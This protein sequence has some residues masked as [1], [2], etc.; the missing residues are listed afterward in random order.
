MIMRGEDSPTFG[1]TTVR[2]R[3]ARS[4]IAPQLPRPRLDK[5]TRYLHNETT[6][7]NLSK[8]RIIK[9]SGFENLPRH[10]PMPRTLG[11]VARLVR[12]AEWKNLQDVRRVYPH[13]DAVIVA[14]RKSRTVFNVGGNKYRLIAAIHYNTGCVYILTC[15]PTPSTTRTSGRDRYDFA[16]DQNSTGAKKSPAPFAGSRLPG[17]DPPIS[18]A[19]CAVDDEYELA[20]QVLDTL[21]VLR[22][23]PLPPASRITLTR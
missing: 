14:K 9:P 11:K 8:M 15:S 10:T 1:L 5:T 20:V 4:E 18:A 6:R 16:G 3:P 23:D 17:D 22:K 13:A 21:V 7:K 19:P 2:A 12:H